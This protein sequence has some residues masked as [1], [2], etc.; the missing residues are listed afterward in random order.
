MAVRGTLLQMM[1]SAGDSEK[2]AM[3]CFWPGSRLCFAFKIFQISD[4][5][6]SALMNVCVCVC[7]SQVLVTVLSHRQSLLGQHPDIQLSV[8]EFLFVHQGGRAD[9]KNK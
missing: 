8:M 4:G 5:D 9:Q 7:G 1:T 6:H 2:M 3:F